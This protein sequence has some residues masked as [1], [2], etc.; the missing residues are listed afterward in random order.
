MSSPMLD[1]ED[2]S[3]Q[4]MA[5]LAVIGWKLLGALAREMEMALADRVEAGEA[6]IRFSQRKLDQ[7]LARNDLKLVTYDGQVWS[8]QIPASPLNFG[9]VDEGHILIDSTIEPTILN[10]TRVIL[11]GKILLRNA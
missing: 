5:D 3:F 9:E 11:P 8:P 4:T 10:G 1:M 6:M 7:T 2:D